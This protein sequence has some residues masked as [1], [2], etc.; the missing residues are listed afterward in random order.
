MVNGTVLI[1]IRTLMC[2]YL[3]YSVFFVSM[4]INFYRLLL[5][6]VFVFGI[7]ITVMV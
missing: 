1:F 6:D 3:N 4:R 2:S 7:V 5:V